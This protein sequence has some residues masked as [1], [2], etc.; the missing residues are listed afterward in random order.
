MEFSRDKIRQIRHLMLLGAFLVLVLIYSEKVFQGIAFL[1]GILSPFAVGGVIAF[2]LNIPMRA[3]EEKLLACWKGKGAQK[4][5]RPVCM[6]LSL[7]SVV[8]VI[9]VVIGT[10]VPQVVATAAEV[11]KKI[12]AFLDSIIQELD[13]LTKKYPILAEQVN[14]LETLEMN[15]DSILNSIIDFLKNGAGDVLNSTVNVASGI[16]SGVVNAVIS[17]IFA[18]YILSQKENLASQGCRILTAYLPE[19]VS[20]KTMEVCS[21]LHRNFS[22]FITGQCLEAVILGTMFVISMSLFRMPYALMVGVLI[23]FT[24]LIPIVG[25]FIGCVVGAFLILIDDPLLA[26]WFIILFLVLQQIEGNLIYPKVVGNSVGLP[27]IWVLMAVSV[28][29]SL[30]GVAGMLFFIPLMSSCYALL[31][32]SVN[33]R[34]AGKR[35]PVLTGGQG[36][37]PEGKN[38]PRRRGGAGKGRDEAKPGTWKGRDEAKP[39]TWK[40]RDEAKAGSGKDHAGAKSNEEGPH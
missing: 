34:N 14:K 28:G 11:G 17:F 39:G 21:L 38:P 18:L 4:L 19:A 2:V 7:I 9:T 30:F 16:I 1:F 24:A 8:L 36:S 40:G 29:G 37:K 26:L 3:F 5:K 27:A 23:A 25:A 12:P 33:R 22:S 15:W 10:V 31:R 35:I 6:V 20:S 13:D 32:E